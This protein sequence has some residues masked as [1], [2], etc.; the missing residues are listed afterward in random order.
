VFDR[1]GRRVGLVAHMLAD[2]VMDIFHGL[3]VHTVPL[4]GRHLY[5]DANQIAGLRER[6]WC[7]PSDGRTSLWIAGWRPGC[8]E[9]GIG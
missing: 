4:P 2:E 8:A 6:V 1:E 5:A 7:C 3:I 9:S